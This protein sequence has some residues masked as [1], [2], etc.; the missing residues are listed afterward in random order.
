MFVTII[1]RGHGGTRA[2]SHTLSESGFYMGAELNGSGDLVP[3][4]EFYEACRVMGRHVKHLGGVRWDFSALHTMPIDPEF[5]RLIESYLGSVLNSDAPNKGWKLPETILALP[6]VIRMFPDLHYIFW[7][8]DPRDSILKPHLTD[9]IGDLGVTYDPVDDE[10]ERRAVSWRYQVEIY[11]ATPKPKHLV[12][13]RF[14]DFVL[15]QEEALKRLED[16]LGVPLARIEV[17]PESVGRWKTD[18]GQHT[19]DCFQDELVR[20]GYLDMSPHGAT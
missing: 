17:R 6:W 7:V 1:G 11:R 14:E 8:R 18:G 16:F 5:T 15:K 4:D 2:M 13:V 19:F 12:E 3:A 9:D 10:R 20:L